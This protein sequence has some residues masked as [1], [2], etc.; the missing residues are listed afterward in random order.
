VLDELGN[1]QKVRI[2]GLGLLDCQNFD[3]MKERSLPLPGE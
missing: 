2:G 3:A 1:A